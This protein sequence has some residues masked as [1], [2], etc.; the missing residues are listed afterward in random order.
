MR[1]A[2]ML[3]RPPKYKG[4]RLTMDTTPRRATSCAWVV[5]PTAQ[6]VILPAANAKSPSA[7]A[8]LRSVDPLRRGQISDWLVYFLSTLPIQRLQATSASARCHPIKITNSAPKQL[9]Y[10]S[11]RSI[12]IDAI[13]SEIWRRCGYIYLMNRNRVQANLGNALP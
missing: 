10:I 12:P 2:K 1:S 8:T 3:V 11:S 9:A 4:T 7:A 13:R 6:V 5:T